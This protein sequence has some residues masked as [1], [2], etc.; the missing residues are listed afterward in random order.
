VHDR[1][2]LKRGKMDSPYTHIHDRSLSK[3]AKSITLTHTSISLI[4]IHHHSLLKKEAKSI[5]LSHT[6][7]SLIHIHDHSLLKKEA[8]SY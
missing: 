1:Y 7:I 4:H 5:T 6:S 3:E 8:K 2:D